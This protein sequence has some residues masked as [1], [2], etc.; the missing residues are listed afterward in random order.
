[1]S[2]LEI[3][4]VV[5][6]FCVASSDIDS[7]LVDSPSFPTLAFAL[8]VNLPPALP[9]LPLLGLEGE[10]T[11]HNIF[12]GLTTKVYHLPREVNES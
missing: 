5:N 6:V 4:L 8:L 9:N 11:G 12:F 2:K 1:M 10:K 7:T 3:K